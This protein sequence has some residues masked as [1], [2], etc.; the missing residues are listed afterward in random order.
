VLRARS[1]LLGLQNA[2]GHWRAQ[3]EGDS[4][5]E[6]EY[7]LTMY[8]LGRSSEAKVAKA[9]ETL[10]RAQTAGGG[11]SSFPGGEDDVN[12]TVK[13]YFALKLLGE[14]ADASHMRAAARAARSLGGPEACNSF[15]KIYLAIFG[16][17]PWRRCPAVPPEL[18]L[19]PS[20]VPFNVYEMSSWSRAIVVPL[21]IIRALR[22]RCEVPAA[23]GIGELEVVP[24][25]E[26]ARAGGATFLRRLFGWVDGALRLYEKAP[27][28]P[29]RRLALER[30][31][32]WTLEHLEH[33][34]GLGAIFPPIVNSIFALRAMGRESD[35]AAVAAQ[36]EELERLE[37]EG[38]DTLKVQPCFSP[39]WDT[40]LAIGAVLDAGTP[41]DA[42]SV[43]RAASWL[44]DREVRLVGDWGRRL[45]DAEPGGWYFEYA[46][47]F[48]PDC[49]DTAQVVNS[50]ARVQPRDPAL[51]GRL[52]GALQRGVAW[53]ERL[54]NRDGGWGAFDQDCD[55]EFLTHVP[56]ADHNAMID[57]STVDVSARVVMALLLAGRT[58][59]DP[60]VERGL[61]FLR[62]QQ[63]P[64]GAWF[65]R[66]GCNYIYGTWLA[67][68]ALRLSG[69]NP[70]SETIDRA[71]GWLEAH[72]NE[73]GGWG[74]LP[75]SYSEP[76]ARGCGPSTACQTGWALL[77][78]MAGGAEESVA[79]DRG[80]EYLL[81][82]Q[83]ESGGW[84]DR[85]WTGTGFPGVFYLHYHL[86]ATYFP[87]MAL[88]A[89]RRLSAGEDPF[90]LPVAEKAATRTGERPRAL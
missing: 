24:L 4:I 39:V 15:T 41:P 11:W 34:Q 6:S 74:E 75:L 42:L 28:H 5:L 21:S 12:S 66:W 58:P 35:A 48:Y 77:G 25:P 20:W 90:A 60:V 70:Q 16:Q 71:M 43:A 52:T 33:S 89:H 62:L 69:E 83:E 82:R 8:S 14:P 26:S 45:P 47:E 10:R 44:L 7:V 68:S 22:P 40:A 37:I 65:G 86:Y 38:P 85:H 13:A 57:P 81:R 49:D 32:R 88:A 19:L 87:L 1:Y 31:R 80:L 72:Q 55:R 61:A 84:T 27:F 56:F 59:R 29:L 51:A 79:L 9:G 23:L 46:N 78:L 53:L 18:L 50:L 30:A 73:D 17:H 3:L 36:I 2:D 54:Q 64:D 76:T 67:L 63:E